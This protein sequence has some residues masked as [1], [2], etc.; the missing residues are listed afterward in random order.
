MGMKRIII[1]CWTAFIIIIGLSA[2]S[3]NEKPVAPFSIANELVVLTAEYTD[4]FYVDVNGNYAG[5]DYDLVNEFAREMGLDVR[6][7]VMPR[8]DRAITA[9]QQHRA[10][11]AVG[12]DI[13]IEQASRFRSGPVYLHSHH[14]LAFNAKNYEP[15]DLDHLVGKLIEVPAG[16]SHEKQLKKIK[17]KI[18]ELT[19][20]S[21]KLS[22]NDLLA[23]LDKG[24]INYTVAHSISIKKAS[25][26]Y[27]RV[28]GAFELEP[29]VSQWVFPKYTNN[30]LINKV[31]L[32]F[33]RILREGVLGQLMN[34][35]NGHYHQL[36]PGD[37]YF[38]KQ[39]IDAILP[40]F[41]GYFLKAE[42]LT[43]IDWRLIAAL[44]YQESHWNPKA[45]SPT[46]VRG[47]M[48]LTRDTVKRMKVENPSDSEQSILAG[49]RYLQLLMEKLPETISEPD[50]TWIALAAYNQGLG[51][52]LDAR[53]LAKRFNLNPDLWSDLKKTLPLLNKKH[54]S[55]TLKYGQA[56]GSEAVVL[57]ESV[58]AYYDVLKR[59]AAED[60]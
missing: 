34:N 42:N 50:R 40:S 16:S 31:N 4:N 38:F 14:Q 48:M 23:K 45:K 8:I 44:A 19:W 35:Y 6:F 54:Y 11:F 46:G 20:S 29:S 41:N 9:L 25:H 57:T 22:S 33:E 12:L 59:I 37:I 30:E 10:H 26:F 32:F 2:C 49:A 47:I 5:I 52:I 1:H 51:R 17:Q 18:P 3:L 36:S 7:I 60:S 43:G 39:K 58:R 55:S 56:R 15:M 13:P 21:V 28:K 53:T 27:P 24:E